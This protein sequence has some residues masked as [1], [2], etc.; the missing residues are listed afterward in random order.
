LT[1]STDFPTTPFAF[2]R[3][4]PGADAERRDGFVARISEQ[5][6]FDICIQN[7]DGRSFLRINSTT[8]EYLFVTCD[9][10]TLAGTGAV[11]KKGCSIVLQDTRIDRRVLATIDNCARRATAS[12]R[13]I[14]SGRLFTVTDR[15]TT[16]NSCGCPNG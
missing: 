16:N 2:Q 3:V 11:T 5:P 4:A 13:I 10:L 12:V 14:P 8:G 9:G 6:P 1:R 7:D 15:N